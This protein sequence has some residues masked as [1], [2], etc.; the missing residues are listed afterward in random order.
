MH[1]WGCARL[2]VAGKIVSGAV[3]FQASGFAYGTDSQAKR[4][5]TKCLKRSVRIMTGFDHPATHTR[6]GA[7]PRATM[8]SALQVLLPVS[9]AQIGQ[10]D[11]RVVRNVS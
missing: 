10:N 7:L 8:P 4:R 5:A 1:R 3:H 9:S 2:T 6:T 11:L